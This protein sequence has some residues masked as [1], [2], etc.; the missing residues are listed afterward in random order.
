MPKMNGVDVLR[1]I[2]NK[3]P[4]TLARHI[5]FMTN[6]D[7]DEELKEVIDLTDGYMMKSSFT[8]QQFIAEIKS[9]LNK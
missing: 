8:P 2:R 5:V 3:S 7:I 1:Q 9:Y 6:S 4:K